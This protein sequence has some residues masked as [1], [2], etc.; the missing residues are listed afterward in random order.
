MKATF[1]YQQVG[2]HSTMPFIPLR[3]T[4]LDRTLESVALID[5]GASISVLPHQIGT[6]LN[7]NWDDYT[8]GPSLGGSLQASETRLVVLECDF[9]G[10]G[11]VDL[12]FAWAKVNTPRILLGQSNFFRKFK[13]C[14]SATQNAIEVTSEA[15][16]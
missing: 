2:R 16:Q 5:S 4:A 11:Q 12:G 3:L 9:E 13:V 7:L 8:P 6:A 14:F 1:P 15:S 10:L